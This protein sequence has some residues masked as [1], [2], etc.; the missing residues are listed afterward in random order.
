MERQPLQELLLRE[1][2]E[3][4]NLLNPINQ[5]RAQQALCWEARH[6]WWLVLLAAAL[7]CVIGHVWHE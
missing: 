4:F 6:L 7:G 2:V 5:V 1:I 3:R